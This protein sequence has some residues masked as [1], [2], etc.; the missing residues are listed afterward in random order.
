MARRYASSASI[1][2]A[3]SDARHDKID[4]RSIRI[5]PFFDTP[6]DGIGRCEIRALGTFYVD[7]RPRGLRIGHKFYFWICEE[8]REHHDEEGQRSDYGRGAPAQR[9]PEKSGIQIE[10]YRMM[11]ILFFGPCDLAPRKYRNQ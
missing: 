10:R 11:Q 5:D 8:D 2:S 1:R 3:R 4:I 7:V 6:D 9:K